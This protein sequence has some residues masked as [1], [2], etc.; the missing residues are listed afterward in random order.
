MKKDSPN[1]VM[2][3]FRLERFKAAFEPDAVDLHPFTVL[4]GRNGSGKST[5]LE[6]LQWIDTSMRFDARRAC[7]RYYGIRDLVN[8]RSRI[9]PPFFQLAMTWKSEDGSDEGGMPSL[10]I[11]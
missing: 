9:S 8:L 4:V 2:T 1:L 3:S 11:G 5:L 7:E 6:A 10:T